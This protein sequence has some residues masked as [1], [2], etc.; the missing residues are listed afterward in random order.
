VV[1]GKAYRV[2]ALLGRGTVGIVHT[3]ECLASGER[4]AIKCLPGEGPPPA[5]AARR[6]WREARCAGRLGGPHSIKIREVGVLPGGGPF[7]VM[8]LLDGHDLRAHL[9][10]R[11]RLAV[12]EAAGLVAQ[13]CEA[14]A[15]AHG[16]GIVH[17]DLKPSNLFLSRHTSGSPWLTVIDFGAASLRGEQPEPRLVPGEAEYAAPEQIL[18][19]EQAFPGGDVW[20][21]GVILFE[22]LTGSLPFQAES[23]SGLFARI[24]GEPAPAVASRRG[25]LPAELGPLLARCLARS[26]AERPSAAALGAAL[27]RLA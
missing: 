6:L 25:D 23:R 12:G 18:E 20:S 5:F 16:E 15:E 22:L 4:V 26:P 14:I 7:L 8:D 10:D 9:A 2:G 17:R 11:G 3:A 19:P 27:A 13:A 1:L 24:L 21:L